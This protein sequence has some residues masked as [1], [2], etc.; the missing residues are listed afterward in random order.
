[1]PGSEPGIAPVMEPLVVT[2]MHYLASNLESCQEL[3]D[4]TS[5]RSDDLEADSPEGSAGMALN[6][7]NLV[8]LEVAHRRLAAASFAVLR[9]TA[10]PAGRELADL[11][12]P[13]V[14]EESET[15]LV[16][17]LLAQYAR[18]GILDEIVESLD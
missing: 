2:Q 7:L 4:R 6:L 13:R 14:Y 11:L 16:T 18:E 5:I 9:H 8:A 10:G 1:M 3:D 15:G 12:S 17:R